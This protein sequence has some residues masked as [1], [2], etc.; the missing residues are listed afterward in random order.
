M[1]TVLLLFSGLVLTVNIEFHSVPSTRSA[2]QEDIIHQLNFL[3]SELKDHRLG[4]RMQ[5][6]FPEGYVFVNALYGLAWCELALAMPEDAMLLNHA[7]TEALYAYSN[8]DIE[9]AR[10]IFPSYIKP[11]YGVFYAGWK[12]YLLSKILT[13]PAA[14][15]ERDQYVVRFSAQCDTL[16]KFINAT[17]NPYLESYVGAAW[18]S[19]TFVAMASVAGYDQLFQPRYQRSIT[20]WIDKVK[21]HLD[22]KTGMV[23]HEVDAVTGE[24]THGARGS[25]S[26]LMLR[27]LAEIDGSFGRE[28]YD[29]VMKRF[30]ITRCGLPALREYPQGQQGPGDVDSGPVIFDVGFSG[31]IVMM[32]TFAAYHHPKEAIEQFRA[33]HA[34]GF[35]L[36]TDGQ[37]QYLFGK[38]PMADAFIT[39]GMA[40]MVR[41]EVPSVNVAGVWPLTFHVISL[42]ILLVVWIPY[43][44]KSI[45]TKWKRRKT[46]FYRKH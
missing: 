40:T 16:V 7:T 32:G 6:L 21:K 35:T 28:Q 1:P 42:G 18:P 33:I 31:T 9:Y 36:E 37:R 25:S 26:A 39:W 24:T 20:D 5:V 11:S 13:L 46:T 30:V 44:W 22:P 17:E 4:E 12:N 15:P 34:F 38:L 8:L 3:S 43:F 2:Y 14:F 10:S 27:M 23:P 41:Y 29:L 45:R 19:D